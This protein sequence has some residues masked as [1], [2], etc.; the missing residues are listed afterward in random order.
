MIRTIY[1]R[2]QLMYMIQKSEVGFFFKRSRAKT[3]NNIEKKVQI[4]PYIVAN[5]SEFLILDIMVVFSHSLQ[6][7]TFV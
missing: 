3:A 5:N 6:K 2:N 4:V 1:E 7:H